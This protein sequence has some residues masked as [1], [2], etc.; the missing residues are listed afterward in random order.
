M[1]SCVRQ[2][3]ETSSHCGSE[4]VLYLNT[5]KLQGVPVMVAVPNL[6][7]NNAYTQI[8][9]YHHANHFPSNNVA[10]CDWANNSQPMDLYAAIVP[11]ENQKVPMDNRLYHEL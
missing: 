5:H 2:R 4:D 6:A 11:L 10:P 9:L 8:A 3:G 1:L 7:F